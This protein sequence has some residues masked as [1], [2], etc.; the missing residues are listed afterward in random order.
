[1]HIGRVH[2]EHNVEMAYEVQLSGEVCASQ[3]GVY[4]GVFLAPGVHY[5]LFLGAVAET[6]YLNIGVCG[7][8]VHYFAHL[9]CRV[10]FALVCGKRC[11][12]HPFVVAFLRYCALEL[13]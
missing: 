9:F 2:T 5:G 12:T 3:E 7:K 6:E 8:R 11:Y 1:M 4:V 13:G 10:N